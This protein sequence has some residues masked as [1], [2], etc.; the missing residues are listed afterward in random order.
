MEKLSQLPLEAIASLP[1]TWIHTDFSFRNLLL[2]SPSDFT[3]G[4][5]TT[6]HII[7]V[8]DTL[9]APRIFD[10]V[11]AIHGPFRNPFVE[12]SGD[13]LNLNVSHL[14][15]V[16]SVYFKAGGPPFS[17]EE[18]RLA[19]ACMLLW[20]GHWLKYTELKHILLK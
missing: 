15:H 3:A 5:S 17:P 14:S 19:G 2:D 13:H 11:F 8:T 18:I 16:F 10:F 7:D 1:C 9:I 4:S 6:L 20:C 12:A